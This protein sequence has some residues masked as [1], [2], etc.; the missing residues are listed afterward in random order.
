MLHAFSRLL[1]LSG[2]LFSPCV[3]SDAT[4]SNNKQNNQSS[5]INDDI[6]FGPGFYYGTW[7]DNESD[8]WQW[9][10]NHLDYPPNRDYYNHD[11]PVE[12]HHEGMEHR[13]GG[14]HGGGHR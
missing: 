12:Y 2:L 3:Y 7:F 1:V 4:S 14:G 11:H 8:Y 5:Q 10:G 13:E 6:W 9:R